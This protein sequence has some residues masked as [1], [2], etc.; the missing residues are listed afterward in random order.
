MQKN[1]I[2]FT[3][4]IKNAN[5]DFMKEHDITALLDNLLENAVESALLT[6]DKFIDFLFAQEIQIL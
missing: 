2:N 1:K 3:I 6:D 5:L 4:S